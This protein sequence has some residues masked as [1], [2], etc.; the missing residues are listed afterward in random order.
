MA[1]STRQKVKTKTVLIS[2]LTENAG[3]TVLHPFAFSTCRHWSCTNYSPWKSWN[4]W[5]LWLKDL[6]WRKMVPNFVI[7]CIWFSGG[8]EVS[9]PGT[10]RTSWNE[11]LLRKKFCW[12]FCSEGSRKIIQKCLSLMTGIHYSIKRNCLPK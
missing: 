3:N 6:A 2:M 12:V 8:L 11:N 7:L 9:F 1:G 5:W 4:Q 10:D